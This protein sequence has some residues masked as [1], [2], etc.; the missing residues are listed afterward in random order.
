MKDTYWKTAQPE[1]LETSREGVRQRAEECIFLDVHTR[2]KRRKWVCMGVRI[3]KAL[4]PS[5]INATSSGRPL[6]VFKCFA[7]R[8]IQVL[9]SAAYFCILAFWCVSVS[10]CDSTLLSLRAPADTN[11]FCHNSWWRRPAS[12]SDQQRFCSGPEGATQGQLYFKKLVALFTKRPFQKVSQ[13]DLNWWFC[14][15][16]LKTRFQPCRLWRS[17]T[18]AAQTTRGLNA[19]LD[20]S[21]FWLL[22]IF[23]KFVQFSGCVLYEKIKCFLAV[24]LNRHRQHLWIV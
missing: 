17:A 22:N 15:E 8:S 18:C 10:L 23:M 21:H 5:Y 3:W 24:L 13:Q 1:Y 12:A 2:W 14:A 9:S 20:W 7:Q 11:R 6:A 4:S 19:L 16:E